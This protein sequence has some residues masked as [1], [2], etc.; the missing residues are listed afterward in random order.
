[1]KQYSWR[2]VEAANELQSISSFDL[3]T[4]FAFFSRR[5]LFDFLAYSSRHFSISLEEVSESDMIL[6]R[7]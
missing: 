3:P 4:L 6:T 5:A 1:M 2:G 7:P